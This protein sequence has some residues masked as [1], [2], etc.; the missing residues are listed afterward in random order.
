MRQY[1]TQTM[2]QVWVDRVIDIPDDV[3]IPMD[4]EY[5]DMEALDDLMWTNLDLRKRD[6]DW[7]N[8]LT[9]AIK[10][11]PGYIEYEFGDSGI[12]RDIVD[13]ETGESLRW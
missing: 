10:A 5:P 13:S 9:G 7:Y 2:V 3:E 4:G 11:L 8:T 12:D 6:E 1:R